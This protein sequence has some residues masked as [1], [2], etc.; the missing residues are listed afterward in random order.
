MTDYP[1]IHTHRPAPAAGGGFRLINA[2]PADFA[3]QA[4]CLYSVGLHPWTLTADGP[5]PDEWAR[6]AEAVR[7]PQV[8]AVGEAGLDKLAEA[9][10]EVQEAVLARQARLAEET[11]KPLV[12]HLV[13]AADELLR[14]RKRLRPRMPWVIHGFR[15][16]EQL[17]A[18]WVR[19]GLYLSFGAQFRAEALR[20]VPLDR[21]FLETDESSAPIGTLYERAAALLGSPVQS[22][23]QALAE[24]AAK[25]FFS[26]KNFASSQKGRIFAPKFD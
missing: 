3:P 17:A 19:H 10:L 11:G 12:V 16:K 5:G 21:L 18:E 14:L 13:R 2:S 7:L 15:G 1:D 25:C 6:L 24:N 23:R 26:G 20:A 4:G 22:L 9:P 8:L